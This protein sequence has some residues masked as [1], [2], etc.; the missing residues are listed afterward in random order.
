MVGW[1]VSGRW[2]RRI[3]VFRVAGE[4]SVLSTSGVMEWRASGRWFRVNCS[5]SAWKKRWFGSNLIPRK[6]ERGLAL[7]LEL[8][9]CQRLEVTSRRLGVDSRIICV[10]WELFVS[11]NSY[12][13]LRIFEALVLGQSRVEAGAPRSW[14]LWAIGWRNPRRWGE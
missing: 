1:S 9:V 3:S 14:E 7:I 12:D 10:K 4:L 2:T 8:F 13:G 11:R 5:F 6:I